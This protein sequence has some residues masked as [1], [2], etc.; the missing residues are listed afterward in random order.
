MTRTDIQQRWHVLV[1]GGGP[2]GMA[3][4][5]AAAEAGRGVALIDDNHSLGGQIWRGE[6]RHPSTSVSAEWYRRIAAAPLTVIPGARVVDQP[7]PG[8]LTIESW[9]GTRTV[10]YEMLVLATGA[11]ERF[12]P[13]PGWTLPNVMGA[14]GLQALVKSGLPIE[15][16]RVVVAGS[17][18][19]LLA[20][21]AYLK[22]H[23]A[24]V[25][26]VAEQTSRWLLA[27]FAARL[28]AHPGKAIQALALQYQLR[29]IP[30]LSNTW[31]V[32]AEGN[33][34]L[35]RVTLRRMR[36]G[37]AK[38]RTWTV[39]CDY[40]ACGFALVPNTELAALV[41]CEVRNGVVQVDA[42]QETSV[43]GVYCAGEPTGIGG[44]D[45]ALVEGQIA[46]HAAAGRR[47]A[48]KTLL[49]ERNALQSFSQLLDRIFALR[50]ELRA[51]PELDTIVCRC[52]DVSFGRLR[53]H[54]DWRSA[55]LET[56]CGMG[57]CQGRVCG[58]A[59]EFLLE[60]H[61]ESVRPP[62]FPA[63]IE[64]LIYATNANASDAT[65]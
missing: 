47:D 4:A 42:S 13:F 11:R 49:R 1:V 54:T 44:L 26:A 59:A 18:P 5:C 46:G 34:V 24:Q 30:Y 8:T 20:V 61:V 38:D 31:P 50:P 58:A 65:Q 25:V 12:L 27:Q 14:G 17:G 45:R 16:K 57:P 62:V 19:L 56:R 48:A 6:S 10:H 41:G 23:G 60:W 28:V 22:Q 43:K 36:P 55:K 32:S 7:E 21:A 53:T 39:P 29:G 33:G 9:H 2:A 51:L 52:E 40:L 3:A 15:G 64:A 63:S 37:G 35:E